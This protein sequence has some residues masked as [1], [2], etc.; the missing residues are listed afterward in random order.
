MPRPSSSAT[1]IRPDLGAIAYSYYL[2]ASRRGF[3]GLELMPIFPTDLKAA[4]YPK[5]PI[6]A[7][8]KVPETKRAPRGNYPRSDWEFG[9][10]DY[11]C[12]EYGW[13]EPVDDSEAK[14]Y[15]MFFD[16][17]VIAIQ[18]ATDTLLR[19]QEM[20]IARSLFNPANITKTDV[21]VE[22]SKPATATPRADINK[23]KKLM[24][25]ISGLVPN[26]VAMTQNVFDNLLLTAEVKEAFKYTNPIEIGGGEAQRRIMAQYLGVDRVLVGDAIYD[27]AKKGQ[28]AN[29]NEVWDDEY[30]MLTYAT[31]TQ[32]K[33]LKEPIVGRT[34]LW[35]EDSPDN[36]VTEQYREEQTR[37]NIY[38][39]RNNVAEEFV[40]KGAAYL[41]GNITE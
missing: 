40:F 4:Q 5:I 24:R 20:R 14:L 25:A 29:I 32:G 15:S 13:E 7:M 34:F 12:Q 41:L 10:G 26:T 11:S 21:T 36:L 33:D 38:R 19:G 35:K 27:S 23:G 22:W 17:E 31:Q 8:L 28:N 9:I 18:R 1:V 3:I 6:E 30:V 39:V 2:E 37:S 16:S